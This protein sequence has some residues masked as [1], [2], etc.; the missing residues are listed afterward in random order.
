M[1]ATNEN[2]TAVLAEILE[3]IKSLKQ[4][5]SNLASAVDEINGRVNI[6]A[7]VKQVREGA[8]TSTF[9]RISE[10]LL[11]E[12]HALE[13]SS[14]S[15]QVHISRYHPN[16]QQMEQTK[17][18]DLSLL[19]RASSLLASSTNDHRARLMLHPGDHLLHFRRR[20]S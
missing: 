12:W 4:E 19:I 15:Q 8:G 20:L 1:A 17:T 3:S 18:N 14:H 11:P 9:C 13:L 10:A 7:G 16:H 2:I 5:G 6:L